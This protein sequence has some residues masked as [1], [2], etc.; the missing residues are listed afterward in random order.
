MAS[1]EAKRWSE[2]LGNDKLMTIST[3][4]NNLKPDFLISHGVGGVGEQE[5]EGADSGQQRESAHRAPIL[6]QSPTRPGLAPEG[7]AVPAVCD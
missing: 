7:R 1:R 2:N 6:W 3:L 5:R 4:R